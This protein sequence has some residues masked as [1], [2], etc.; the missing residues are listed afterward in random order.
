MPQREKMNPDKA[1]SP[2]P[3]GN[4]PWGGHHGCTHPVPPHG[5]SFLSSTELLN[6]YSLS[7][8]GSLKI[9]PVLMG[10]GLAWAGGGEDT[11]TTGL[12]ELMATLPWGRDQIHQWGEI[13][14]LPLLWRCL[15][16]PQYFLT[17]NFS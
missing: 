13:L 14:V 16:L 3:A 1:V 15:H 7:L 9:C 6:L 2:L 17:G 10:E 4:G 11:A 8:P 12:E 5:N